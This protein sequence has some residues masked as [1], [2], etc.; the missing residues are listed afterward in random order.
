ML[1]ILEKQDTV[2]EYLHILL[3]QSKL[4]DDLA[5]DIVNAR[6]LEVIDCADVLHT[7][8]NLPDKQRAGKLLKYL[9]ELLSPITSTSGKK[10]QFY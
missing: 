5:V 6:M 7:V 4:K 1:S 8:L 2:S 10:K 9:L 3:D